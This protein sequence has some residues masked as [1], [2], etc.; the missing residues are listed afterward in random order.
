MKLEER[1]AQFWSLLAFAAHNQ[2][3]LS[4][5]MVEEL[6]GIPRFGM[7]NILGQIQSYCLDSNLPPLTCIVVA[8]DTGLPKEGFIG[9]PIEDI[10]REQARVFIFDWKSHKPP[11]LGKS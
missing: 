11:F 6:T 3:I 1:A 4:Y 7:A 5:R 9:A 8:E 10:F 2:K